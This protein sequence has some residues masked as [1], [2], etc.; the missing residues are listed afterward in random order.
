MFL[1]IVSFY[2]FFQ[3][4]LQTD[5]SCKI[6]LPI[7]KAKITSSFGLR[8][9][10]LVNTN[11]FHS[12]VDLA[13]HVGSSVR[14]LAKGQVIYSG[15]YAGFG[16]LVVIRHSDNLTSH[17]AHLWGIRVHV[18]EI[19]NSGETIGFL[20]ETGR[21]TGAHLHFE[22]RWKGRAINPSWILEDRYACK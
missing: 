11:K 19:V 20:G 14:S 17:Y 1:H 18:G 15:D 8:Q 16:K 21:T 7:K 2:L 4:A 6:T 9:D 3:A 10:P 13:A 12:G 5:I 22:I